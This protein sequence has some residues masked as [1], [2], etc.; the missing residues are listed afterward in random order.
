MNL[1]YFDYCKKELLSILEYLDKKDYYAL[2][3][4]MESLIEIFSITYFCLS[5]EMVINKDMNSNDV[6]S[7]YDLMIPNETFENLFTEEFSSCINIKEKLTDSKLWFV[8]ALRNSILH[9][10][11]MIDLENNM[12]HVSNKTYLNKIK[13]RSNC[14]LLDLESNQI[15]SQKFFSTIYLLLLLNH[16]KH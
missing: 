10:A 6:N 5:E 3:K 2:Y 12:L 11:S 9:G 1:S 7:R 4:E 16:A 15:S 14:R 8:S 13:S